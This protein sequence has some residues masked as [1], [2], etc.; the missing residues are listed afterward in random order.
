MI[1][2][3][4]PSALVRVWLLGPFQV[5]WRTDAAT[6]ET[7]E[8][9]AWEGSYA[10]LLFK[11][12]L[13][14]S[15]R[16]STRSELID[17]LWPE[18]SLA[19]AEK[20]LNN[21]SSKLH[22]LLREDH[23]L[24]TFGPRGSAGY[25]LAGQEV[26]WTDIDACETLLAEAERLG[27]TS[28]QALSLLEKASAYVERGGMLE[29]ESGQWVRTIQAEKEVVMRYCLLWLAEAYE[30][31]HMLWHA[32]RQYRRLLARNPLDEE[33]LCRLLAMLHRQ[34]MINDA[35]ALYE[36]AQRRF[37][38]YGLP[39]SET[40][41]NLAQ[42]L[43]NRPLSPDVYLTPLPILEH[44]GGDSHQDEERQKQPDSLIENKQHDLSSLLIQEMIPLGM[45]LNRNLLLSA[46]YVAPLFD[47]G[48]SSVDVLQM[49]TGLAKKVQAMPN[50]SQQQ[51]MRSLLGVGVATIVGSLPDF[52]AEKH[53][54][55]EDRTKL[56][57]AWSESII[58]GWNLF[59][60][61]NMSLVLAVGHSQLHLLQKT[62][63]E[64]YPSVRPLFYSSVYR[65]IGAAFFY[66]AR[67]ADA[68]HAHKKAYITAVE[69]YDYWNMAE[70]LGWQAGVLKACGQHTESIQ[71]M[72]AALHLLHDHHDSQSLISQSRLLAQCA[73][74]AA[75]LGD[76]KTM[77][78][79]L[80]GSRNLL[81]Q[82]EGNDEFDMAMW[83]LYK[84]TCALYIDDFATAEAYLQQAHISLKPHLTHQHASTALLLSQARAGMG[85]RERAIDAVRA[86]IPYVAA[87]DTP[88]VYRGL[89]DH[90]QHLAVQ[91]PRES[92]VY[93]LAEE[94]QQH[95]QLQSLKMYADGPR[96]LEATL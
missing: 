32:R 21:A 93:Q 82:F 80:D 15:G 64:L 53:I 68:M 46:E 2:R 8:K 83:Q 88:L 17:D 55:A 42:Q 4:R 96:Y 74:S 59:A 37:D 67:Y 51:F 23:L 95:P 84:G 78:E 89:L 77:E 24:T 43:R 87:A 26:V 41:R 69:A 11:R 19:M 81:D 33:S 39:L 13:C 57:Q 34:G 63:S 5:E 73:E 27:R 40:T 6:W 10:R 62:Y 45:K 90:V 7:I 31:Q 47:N 35:R 38:E 58:A 22:H 14:A 72:K 66:Q 54:S 12:L 86:A 9:S 50:I 18:R 76:R 30:A 60:S 1:E 52:S 56:H 25:E 71:A 65:L 75:L 70:S 79:T 94:V 3:A 91:F 92:V 44:T 49:I 29:G 28:P 61:A 16:R 48:W 20:Y 36:E 85:E